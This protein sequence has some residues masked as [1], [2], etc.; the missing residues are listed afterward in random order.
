M[1]KIILQQVY[2]KVFGIFFKFQKG[3]IYENRLPKK[4]LAMG[5]R[6]ENNFTNCFTLSVTAASAIHNRIAYH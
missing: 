2:G 6:L 4:K 5:Q 3:S 1:A